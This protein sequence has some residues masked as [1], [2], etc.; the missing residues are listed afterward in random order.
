MSYTNRT[1][2]MK[3]WD[4]KTKKLK[5]CSYAKSDEYY[6]KFD[7]GLSLGSELMNSKNVSLL[8]TLKFI[9]NISPSSNI[10]YLRLQ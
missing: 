4:T 2:T 7:K 9:Y 5:Y 8:T 10:K 1:A 6:N 3:W